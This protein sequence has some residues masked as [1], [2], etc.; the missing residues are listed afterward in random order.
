MGR[1]PP[2]VLTAAV[3]GPIIPEFLSS[4]PP[5]GQVTAPSTISTRAAIDPAAMVRRAGS[6]D[7]QGLTSTNQLK[8][9]YMP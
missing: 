1:I 7:A 4:S 3:P 9:L 8:A 5:D 2:S 6:R